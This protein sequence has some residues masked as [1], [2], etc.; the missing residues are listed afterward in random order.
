MLEKSQDYVSGNGQLWLDSCYVRLT[1]DVSLTLDL[2][3]HS[4]L[5]AIEAALSAPMPG[6]FD[7]FL[8]EPMDRIARTPT[9]IQ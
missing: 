7:D 5:G 9:R 2:T 1:T 4:S 3:I 6:A 8:L